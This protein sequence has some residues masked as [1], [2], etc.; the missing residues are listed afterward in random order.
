[1]KSI[2]LEDLR[3]LF[4][5]YSPLKTDLQLIEAYTKISQSSFDSS[6]DIRDTYNKLI[7]RGFLN[8][9]VIKADF[10]EKY[11]FKQNPSRMI[12][13]F[14]LNT[15]TSRAD[16]CMFNGKSMV[17]E[18]KTEYDTFTRLDRQL[19]DYKESLWILEFDYT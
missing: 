4:N 9:S 11:S 12:S 2:T 6:K 15:G 14:E 19:S 18:I 16:I 8:E 10:I 13:V 7:Q 3:L 1:M 17:F 5:Y